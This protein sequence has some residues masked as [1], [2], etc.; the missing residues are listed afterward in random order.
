MSETP[1][2]PSD[3][4]EHWFCYFYSLWDPEDVRESNAKNLNISLS[5]R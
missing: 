1:R 5:H 4:V 2:V 3:A